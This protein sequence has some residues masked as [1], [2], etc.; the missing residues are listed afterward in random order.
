MSGMIIL[1][2]SSFVTLPWKNGGGLTRE[3]LRIPAEPTVFDWRLSLATIN[4]PGPFSD[5][6]GFERTLVLVRGTGVELDFGPHGRARL[7][8]AGQLVTFDGAWPVS[9][10]LLD[11]PS[12]DLNLIVSR[13]RMESASQSL[14][15]S[16]TEHVQTAGWEDT[17]VCCISGSVQLT[18]SNGEVEN[19][20]E[21]DVARCSPNDRMVTCASRDSAQAHVFVAHVRHRTSKG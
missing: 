17:L 19:L 12:S 10:T 21:A 2:E 3:I 15:L 1:R 9:C 16:E 5:F 13:D 8:A 4:S 14:Q 6:E 20:G 11:G 18:N 7:Q